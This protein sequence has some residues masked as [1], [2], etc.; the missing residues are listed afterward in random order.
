[1]SICPHVKIGPIIHLSSIQYQTEHFWAVLKGLQKD[2]TNGWF[3]QF[4]NFCIKDEGWNVK[5]YICN[6]PPKGKDH[7]LLSYH[8]FLLTSCPLFWLGP[9]RQHSGIEETSII[10]TDYTSSWGNTMYTSGKSLWHQLQG[11]WSAHEKTW[12]ISREELPHP[13]KQRHDELWKKNFF[14]SLPLPW[15]VLISTDSCTKWCWPNTLRTIQG[16]KDTIFHCMYLLARP[17]PGRDKRCIK[18]TKYKQ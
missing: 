18:C 12:K 17:H 5:K 15:R 14:F 13:L 4:S 7:L 3:Q 2:R 10:C 11:A 8:D 16:G 1:M 6:R 9:R